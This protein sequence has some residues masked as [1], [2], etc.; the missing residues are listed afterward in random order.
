VVVRFCGH[1]GYAAETVGANITDYSDIGLDPETEYCYVVRST[2]SVGYSAYTDVACATT[3]APP[4]TVTIQVRVN[5]ES[6]DAEENLSDDSVTVDSSDLEM[7]HESQIDDYD[8]E[9][10]MRF[11]NV[12]VPV[13]ATIVSAYIEFVADASSGGDGASALTI[14]GQAADNPDTFAETD[15]NITGRTKTTASAAWN[16]GTWTSGETYQTSDLTTIVQEIVNRGGWIISNAMV[17]L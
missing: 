9:V 5:Q 8:Q 14:Y 4:S 17:L 3:Q 10:G 7:I 6:D 11:Q 16:P 15:E 2:N 1:S 13:G 12:E